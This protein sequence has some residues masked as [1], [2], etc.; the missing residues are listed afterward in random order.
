MKLWCVSKFCNQMNNLY[1]LSSNVNEYTFCVQVEYVED[2]GGNGGNS[3][4]TTF[5]GETFQQLADLEQR[6]VSPLDPNMS[7]TACY[8]PVQYNISRPPSPYQSS[9][10]II[11]NS[12]SAQGLLTLREV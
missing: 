6:V 8:S 1:I 2:P 4:F 7:C 5:E 3:S 11:V 10:G 9:H 12:S